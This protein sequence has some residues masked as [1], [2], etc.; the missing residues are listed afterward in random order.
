MSFC[1]F[2]LL[3]YECQKLNINNGYVSYHTFESKFTNFQEGAFVRYFCNSHY[4]LIGTDTRICREGNWKGAEP[5]CMKSVTKD[6][7]LFRHVEHVFSK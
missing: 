1:F 4:N 5:Y 7:I 3:V 2:L 6:F